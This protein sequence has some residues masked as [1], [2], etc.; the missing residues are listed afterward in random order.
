MQ[1][2]EDLIPGLPGE[3]YEEIRRLP[4][5]AS[6]SLE[7]IR[8]K[9]G[10]PVYLYCGTGEYILESTGTHPVDQRTLSAVCSALLRHS[11][12]AYQEELASGYITLESGYRI[13]FCGRAVV[14]GGRVKTLRN[15]SSL[16]IRRA[17]EIP[18][19]SERCYPYTVDD[20]GRFYN[21]LIVSPPK[22]GKT[23]LL[24]DF[25]RNLSR[26]GFKVGVCDERNEIAG[27]CE[28]GFTYDLGDRTDILSGC[29]KEKGMT[30]LIRSMAPDIISTDEI[31]KEEDCYAISSAVTAGIGLLTTIHGGSYEDVLRSGIGPLIRKGTFQ[32]LIFLTNRPRTGTISGIYDWKNERVAGQL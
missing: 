3:W 8:V 31:G 26:R 6:A 30:M 25:I 18:G 29:P 15:I 23:T 20:S 14:E 1:K 2:M 24:R 12:Y 17:R 16:N 22:C 13:G 11:V 10:K 27:A 4:P 7:E 21:T 19:I 32:R 5:E 28:T 9:I